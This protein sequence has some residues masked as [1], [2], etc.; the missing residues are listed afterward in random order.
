MLACHNERDDI[1][2]YS[3]TR[4]GDVWPLS[5]SLRKPDLSIEILSKR[6]ERERKKGKRWGQKMKSTFGKNSL[7]NKL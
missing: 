1:I 6:E 7:L 5:N 3:L 2:H 4:R